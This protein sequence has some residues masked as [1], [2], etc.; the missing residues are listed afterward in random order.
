M[1][2]IIIATVL[3]FMTLH[4]EDVVHY[5]TKKVKTTNVSKPNHPSN[6]LYTKK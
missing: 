6:E 1:K 4:A 5:D 3:M 2:K